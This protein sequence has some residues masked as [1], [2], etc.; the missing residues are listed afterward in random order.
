[1]VENGRRTIGGQNPGT[2]CL[3]LE[4]VATTSYL[5]LFQEVTLE[6]GKIG[7]S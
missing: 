4:G 3:T 7:H 1:M 2:S 5:S 6:E